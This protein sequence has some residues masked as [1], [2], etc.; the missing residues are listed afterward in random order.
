MKYTGQ[1]SG[2][3]GIAYPG[4]SG[5]NVIVIGLGYAGATAAIECARKGHKVAIYEQ[6]PGVSTLGKYCSRIFGSAFL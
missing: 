3:D 6:T 4:S 5:I 2:P 1:G